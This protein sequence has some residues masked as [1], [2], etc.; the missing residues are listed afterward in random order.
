MPVDARRMRKHGLSM[1]YS[2][3]TD[4]FISL[5]GRGRLEKSIAGAGQGG[6]VVMQLPDRQ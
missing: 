1:R 6:T 3:V 4:W 2:S 5:V